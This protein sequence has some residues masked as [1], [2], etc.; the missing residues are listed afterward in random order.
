MPPEPAVSLR[1]TKYF[2][3]TTTNINAPG[4]T[5]QQTRQWDTSTGNLTDMTD[6]GD[7]GNADDVTYHIDYDQTLALQHIYRA[8]EITAKDTFG[9]VV[10]DRQATYD[11]LGGLASLT[12]VITGGFDPNGSPY[13]GTAATH[14]FKRDAYGNVVLSTDPRGYTLDTVYDSTA[15]TYHIQTTDSFGYVA[16]SRPNY[17]F[18][19]IDQ[20]ID[21]N[22]QEED[23]VY[24]EFGRLQAV[25]G[26]ED[27]GSSVPTISFA[28]SE[29]VGLV[30]AFPAMALTAHKDIL[31]PGDPIATATFVDGL[32]RVI[33]TKKDLEKDTGSGTTV[34]LAVS[35][36][37]TFDARGRIKERGQP[38]F[39]ATNPIT[40]FVLT[41][42]KNT[43][44]YGYDVM[45][46]TTS[47]Q[48]PDG[49]LTT[50]AYGFDTLDSTTRLSTIV[51]DANVNAGGLPGTPHET[52]ANVRGSVVG[53]VQSNHLASGFSTIVT[54]YTYDSLEELLSVTD[55][56]G[57][58]TSSQYDSAG[59]MVALT[60]PDAGLTTYSYD[61]SGNLAV[62]QT[63]QLRAKSE[64]IK[65]AYDF[66]RLKQISYPTSTSVQYFYGDPDDILN[67][68]ARISEEDSEAG[69]KTYE[70]DAL[71]NVDAQTFTLNSI[72]HDKTY[73]QSI[74]YTYDSFGRLLEVRFPDAEIVE[75]AYDAG[76]N[77]TS[78]ASSTTSYLTHVGYDE[79]EQRTRLVA[80]NGVQTTYSYDPL[81][82]RLASLNASTTA[83]PF[84]ALQYKYDLV[85]NIDQIQNTVAYDDSMK[86][87]VLVGP[88][89]QDFTYD[90][91]Y[92][93]RTADGVY[94]ESSKQKFTYGL[95]LTYDAIG[96]ILTKQQTSNQVALNN[97]GKIKPQQGE[98]YSST[99]KYVGTQPHAPSEVDET[100]LSPQKPIARV[101]T[102]DR[103]GNLTQRDVRSITWNEEDRI[104]S[105]S[106]NGSGRKIK[107]LYDGVAG[108][109]PCCPTDA[110]AAA[111]EEAS[112]LPA[113][114]LT[115]PRNGAAP[116]KHVFVGMERVASKQSPADAGNQPPSVFYFHH[117]HL[118]STNFLTDAA[119]KI[120]AHEEYFPTGELWVDETSDPLHV[121]TPYLFTG[122]ELD[123]ATG[124]YYFGARYYDPHIGLWASPD[125][126]LY[127]FMAHESVVDTRRLGLYGYS[128][129]NPLRL[130][131]PN[132][133]DPT[134]PTW[135]RFLK[136]GGGVAVGAVHALVGG[137]GARASGDVDIDT[138]QAAGLI[139]TGLVEF[140][141]GG[142]I[143][144]GGA[145]GGTLCTVA[146]AGACA[147][148]TVV[149]VAGG[150]VVAGVGVASIAKGASLLPTTGSGKPP[151]TPTST[152]AGT[153]A[154]P[155]ID[156]DKQG[157]HIVGHKNF[158]PARRRSE[159]THPDPQ[160]LLDKGAGTGRRVGNRE[161]VD[162][163][164][165][166]GV[167]VD[168]ATGARTET[169]VGTIHYDSRGGA[170]IV[171]SLR[172]P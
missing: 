83:R 73:E 157:K 58:V 17:L 52:L 87:S 171:P 48:T 122:K 141:V 82:R 31:H 139:A 123:V 112:L 32:E 111:N 16:K 146:T 18:G 97:G 38:G 149:V 78:A 103:S 142:D 136:F 124:L 51:K 23:Y 46:R 96:N 131:D 12:N 57:N 95:G 115:S 159:L 55:T 24:D 99:Y 21:I 61:L 107:A 92:Q 127:A 7:V 88:S 109:R 4:V 108:D 33:L 138:G 84:Q 66:N 172:T 106:D 14:T 162:F 64:S 22:T 80:G 8:T 128:F 167:V 161:W 68:A 170:H 74:G 56:N 67:R 59:R 153:P 116:S 154:K 126:A 77:V 89:T 140:G 94:Q 43:T 25:Y 27:I 163:G 28:Y 164:E 65:Y 11:T 34:G 35:G 19:T 39:D 20:I 76:G 42:M 37:V 165:K 36:A 40:T 134:D 158:D 110:L 144:G 114:T 117:D 13:N 129:N 118:G 169:T 10:R 1:D 104:T 45:D 133:M 29:G 60:S 81:T 166:I 101:M 147:A 93:L 71:G 9:K 148:P 156:A 30:N 151:P 47:V 120:A 54:R 70:Y 98:T 3:G 91:L 75:Y 26:P 63:A 90:D 100:P 143:A 137:A 15:Q 168:P 86:G 102:Y 5:T 113:R 50:T 62:R 152:A 53:V 41:S 44:T 150:V 6:F 2:E 135:K 160:K 49:A 132:G 119:Q 69:I 72:A 145:A 130:I 79:F 125:P 105:I 121:Q 85:G 155:K